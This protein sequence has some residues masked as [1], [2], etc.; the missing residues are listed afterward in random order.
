MTHTLWT[1]QPED[2][3][4]SSS[5]SSSYVSWLR[6]QVTLYLTLDNIFVI[7]VWSTR[8]IM[9]NATVSFLCDVASRYIILLNGFGSVVR[10]FDRQFKLLLLIRSW[11][12]KS[13][14]FPTLIV[15]YMLPDRLLVCIIQI[16]SVPLQN[17]CFGIYFLCYNLQKFWFNSAARVHEFFT[18]ESWD[19]F[20][21]IFDVYMLEASKVSPQNLWIIT[22][23]SDVFTTSKKW[24]S[25]NIHAFIMLYGV[26]IILC[27]Q[28]HPSKTE[29]W[30]NLLRVLFR[31]W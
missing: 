22:H 17:M 30:S 5:Y 2:I 13:L 29:F 24:L 6:F 15:S 4:L 21:Q 11:E 1:W 23:C 9:G 16:W 8:R 12:F 31:L 19:S 7:A 28:Y 14:H 20:K 25:Q 3:D 10:R 27:I 18:E 26:P